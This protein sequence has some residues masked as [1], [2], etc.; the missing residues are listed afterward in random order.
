MSKDPNNIT[1]FR[2]RADSYVAMNQFAQAIPDLET[3]L[4]LKPDDP[5]I[6]QNL[7]YVRA[8]AAPPPP[9]VA[10]PPPTPTPMPEGMSM[11][12]KIGLGLGALIVIIIIAVVVSR[13]KGRS[14]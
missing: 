9:R 12:M 3:A 13:K 2:R 1:A 8:K 7:Q 10:A 6:M 11:P 4:R 14:Y 5:D